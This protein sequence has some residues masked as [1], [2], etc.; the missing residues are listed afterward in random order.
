MSLPLLH[1]GPSAPGIDASFMSI[2]TGS[3]NYLLWQP[4]SDFLLWS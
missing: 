3:L 1:A 2:S 4:G